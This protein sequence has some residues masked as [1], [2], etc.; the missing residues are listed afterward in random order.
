MY[1]DT[2]C[3]ISSTDYDDIDQVI[4][5]DLK[6]GVKKL[7]ISGC[8]KDSISETLDLAS[9]YKVIYASIGYHPEEADKITDSDIT[10]LKELITNNKKV[11]AIGEIGLD[12]HYD[13][14][15]DKQL[16]LFNK[17]LELASTLN[18][19]VII[20]S[21]DATLDTINTL[22]KYKLKG[23]IHCFT[24][25]LETATT[26]IKMGFMLGI[27]GVVTFKNSKLGETIKNISLENIVLETD[28]PYLTPEP[29]RGS[30]NSS[31]YIPIIAS[32]IASIK[33]VSL[34]SIEEITTTNALK[35]FDLK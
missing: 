2:H 32:K 31:K 16:A 17:Q 7:I 28:S 20:H 8:T 19:P 21:R 12:Y 6:V 4:E 13:D 27:G 10:K 34:N 3:H 1:I 22:S 11:V 14:N 26:Y 9:K 24:G 5:D 35:L 29:Y 33:E 30:K 23:V 15:R 25:S 18:L